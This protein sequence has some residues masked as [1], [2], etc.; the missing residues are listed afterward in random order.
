MRRLLQFPSS[1]S[2]GRC[3]PL[4]GL[5]SAKRIQQSRPFVGYHEF[6]NFALVRVTDGKSLSGRLA[7]TCSHRRSGA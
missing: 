6:L 1:L 3:A 2:R 5:A 7:R 4:P